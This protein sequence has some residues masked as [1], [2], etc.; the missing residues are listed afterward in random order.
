MPQGYG[1]YIEN[2]GSEDLDVLLVL[3]NG[4]YRSI[5][6]SARAAGNPQL[7]LATNFR[8]AESTFANFPTRE[9]FMPG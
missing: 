6:L 3:N 1:H 4:S 5:S 2:A 7:L 8:G 9:R